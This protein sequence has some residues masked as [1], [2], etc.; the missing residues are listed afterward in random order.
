MRPRLPNCLEIVTTYCFIDNTRFLL[1]CFDGNDPFLFRL[2][3]SDNTGE[4]KVNDKVDQ[5]RKTKQDED[6]RYIYRVQSVVAVGGAQQLF[7][8][9]HQL[10][11]RHVG[12]IG[13]VLYRCDDLT[14]QG[15]NNVA[16]R[17]RQNNIPHDLQRVEAL[18]VSCL[19]LSVCNGVQTAAHDFRDDGRGE[20]DQGNNGFEQQLYLCGGQPE[21]LPF[22]KS[23]AGAEDQADKEPQQQGS[24]PE[25]FYVSRCKPFQDAPAALVTVIPQQSQKGADYQT[26]ENSGHGDDQRKQH[27][28]PQV[29]QDGRI[30][31]DGDASL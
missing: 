26:E 13:G 6:I 28:L 7:H 14:E 22:Q 11:R 21:Q 12:E 30:C 5:A 8:P 16:V 31:D 20:E 23:G 17:L 9:G 10:N 15:G 27:A 1:F 25:N 2:H 19:K 3:F 18:R 29:K 4:S 24:V